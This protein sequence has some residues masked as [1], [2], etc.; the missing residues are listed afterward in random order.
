MS[1]LRIIEIVLIVMILRA[2]FPLVVQLV[3]G[4]LSRG[5]RPEQRFEKDGND[6]FDKG[7]MDIED[8]EYKELK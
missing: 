7:K 2:I 4:G 5:R 1:I 6:R 3:R 8:G